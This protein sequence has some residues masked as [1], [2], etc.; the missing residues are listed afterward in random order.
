V[1]Y[2]IHLLM[3]MSGLGSRFTAA[4]Y[5][6]PKPL[7]DINGTP[8]VQRL[9]RC[10]PADWPSFF[11]MAE[12]HRQTALPELLATLRPSSRPF[13]IPSERLGPSHAAL[14]AL[15]D[16]P[17]DAPV[18]VSY[19]DYGMVWD[20][21]SFERFVTTS[22]CDVAIV[23][24]RGFHAHYLKP[25]MYAYNRMAGGRVV[26]V[27]EKGCFTDDREQEYASAGGY[28][29]RTARLLKEA[30]AAQM[31]Q[32]RHLNGE[33]YTSLTIEAL[34][35]CRPQTDVR[36]FEIPHF[37]QW[38]TPADVERFIFWE[39]TFGHHIAQAEQ[40]GE[41]AQILM[42]MAGHGSRFQKITPLPKPLIAVGED[43]MF[44][45]ALKTLPKAARTVVVAKDSF[46]EEAKAA[47]R[48]LLP[49]PHIVSLEKTPTGQ[50]LS[51]A[52]GLHALDL[53][54]EVL[55][56]SCDHGIVAPEGVWSTL[57]ES[58]LYDAA[59][60]TMTGFPGADDA[61]NS[62]AYVAAHPDKM[63]P[64]ADVAH[65]SVK[66]PLSATP[67]MDPVLVGTFWFRT[68]KILADAIAALQAADVRV[69]GELY[70]DSV[71][72]MMLANGQRVAMVPLTGYIC[73]GDPTS[74][75][76]AMYWQDVFVGRSAAVRPRFFKKESYV[77][78]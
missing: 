26:E 50:A 14:T 58:G 33:Y 68:G 59:I 69:N 66:K 63:G 64:F 6:D 65:V 78:V 71:F 34:L 52:A 42:P 75:A 60:M 49:N 1:T 16:I 9:L 55:V 61:P 22:K 24:Y 12:G 2:P 51:T 53:N 73:W 25:Q 32:K 39:K 77:A 10:F 15:A 57:Q 36:V 48:G 19:C 21:P 20:A 43:A 5:T 37:F 31:D 7:I 11:V 23:S 18:F 17:D 76:E 8:M 54:Q 38:G 67:R 27:R 72:A 29:F 40:A 35:Q 47:S 13:F 45:A 46:A 74:L 62:Y 28:Y 41:V 4:G 70:L 30:I 56:T 3:P 44:V